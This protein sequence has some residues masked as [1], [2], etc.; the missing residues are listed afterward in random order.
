MD[1]AEDPPLKSLQSIAQA[2][3][4]DEIDKLRSQGISRYISLPQLIVCGD[5][6]SGKSSVL[7]AIS[8]VAFPT[9]DGLCTRFVTEVSLR[10]SSEKS[11]SIKILPAPKS[12]QQHRE[13]LN[14][15]IGSQVSLK[16]LPKFIASAKDAMGLSGDSTFCQDI[17]QL[18]ISGP[19]LPHLT[20]VDMPGLIHTPN[21]S[22]TSEDVRIV[23][24]LVEKYMKAPRSIILAVVSA[25][26]DIANQIVL[27][28]A[29]SS[30]PD[31]L[32]TIG[33]IT[34]PDTLHFGSPSEASFFSLAK[35][36]D[37]SFR[38]GWHVLRNAD[39]ADKENSDYDRDETE[40]V[41]FANKAP[42]NSLPRS[43]V[44]I[45]AL[46]T[47]LSKVLFSQIS[48]ELPGLIS[49]IE[50][51]VESCKKVLQ[52]LGPSRHSK[53]DK[54]R[55]LMNIAERFQFLVRAGLSGQY[56]DPFFRSEAG[57]PNRRLRAIVRGLSQEFATTMEQKGHH[58]EIA[59]H[60]ALFQPP[61]QPPDQPKLISRSDF[62][63]E[64][65]VL[66]KESKGRELQG[67]F[68][69]LLV[70]DLFIQQAE[71]WERIAKGHIH[72]C[73]N[74]VK[75]YLDSLVD[76][77]TQPSVRD[78][79]LREIIDPAMD[80]RLQKLKEK[81]DE[82]LTPYTREFPATLNR[83]F[84][85]RMQQLRM[86]RSEE[87][88]KGP[89]INRDMDFYACSELLDC[90]LAYYQVALDV[91]V[92]NIEALAV[93]NCLM[94]GLDEIISGYK[95][96]Q[97]D[98]KELCKFGSESEESLHERSHV[99]EKMSTLE[100]ALTICKHHVKRGTSQNRSSTRPKIP[101]SKYG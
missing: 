53:N 93:E 34:K 18:E 21:K 62:L 61:F 56:S 39:Y 99:T 78:P 65:D 9:N 100:K 86:K 88:E 22:Q 6:S 17:L 10:R 91:F 45:Q 58:R 95:I 8:Q 81:V 92:D 55:Y 28:M 42:W 26:Y 72:D 70:F 1:G 24:S 20:L 64:I 69:P 57:K 80:A 33:V 84:V 82:L 13:Q 67:T 71:P 49:D 54:L 15:F 63:K 83:S 35:N 74:L 89:S 4:L 38:L 52:K 11:A 27:K 96:T 32:R 76:H 30:D 25:K 14:S 29:K 7:E 44:G 97:M 68:N 23:K 60:T 5:Q 16:E 79:V 36:H 98:E 40:R 12:S 48:S 19:D 51:E 3:L 85:M 87:P 77:I 41:F 73:W 94:Q 50:S 66:L 101:L 46:R 75:D 31:G 90:M 37:I 43:D 47:R 59:N 2:E